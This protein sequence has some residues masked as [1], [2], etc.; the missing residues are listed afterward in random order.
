VTIIEWPAFEIYLLFEKKKS[1]FFFFHEW[2][3]EREGER[4]REDLDNGLLMLFKIFFII[5]IT[6]ILI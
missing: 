4:E 1:Y 6:F 5:I 3:R 2:E